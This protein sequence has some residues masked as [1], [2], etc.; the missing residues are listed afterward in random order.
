MGMTLFTYQIKR[1]K[2]PLLILSALFFSLTANG[3]NG[4][5]YELSNSPTQT[6]FMGHIIRPETAM[7]NHFLDNPALVHRMIE[8][9]RYFFTDNP[10]REVGVKRMFVATEGSLGEHE[11][12]FLAVQG[13]RFRDFS[14]RANGYTRS[15]NSTFLGKVGFTMGEH[16][17][18]G[19]NT[20][21]YPELYWPYIMADST[22]GDVKYEKYNILCAYS[23]KIKNV[24]FGVSGEYLG[25]FAFKQN[26]PRIEN[27]TSW[28][29]LKAGAAYQYRR[30]LFSLGLEYTLHRQYMDVRNFRSG[31]FTGFFVEYGFGM[32]DYI[33]SPVFNSTKQQEHINNV[34]ITLAFNS[35]PAKALRMN[36]RLKYNNDR[37]NTEEYTYKLNLYRALT[38]QFDFNYGLLW[39]N[40]TWGVNLLADIAADRRNGR[41]YLFERYVSSVVDG[42]DVYDYKKIG[43]QDRYRLDK[44]DGKLDAEISYFLNEHYTFALLGSVDYF[45]RNE[46]Y[47]E[48]NYQIKN[49]L[50]TP[51]AGL[52]LNYSGNK[53]DVRLR[54]CWGHRS[55]LDNQYRVG[56]EM[57]KH[58]EYQHAFAPYAYYGNNANIWTAELTVS[59]DFSFARLGLQAQMLCV[60]GKR[61]SDIRYDKERFEHYGL[62]NSRYAISLDP[63]VHNANWA[64]LTLFAEF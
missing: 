39:N 6:E 58:T 60:R 5:L 61:L 13:N 47:K 55:S 50:L 17:H 16:K 33:H 20:Q 29:T 45:M 21:R 18:V 12:D 41:E 28:L 48:K 4:Y 63:D 10:L 34:G 57:G 36:A 44:L 49:T 37:M 54:G 35:D 22:G 8:D 7:R 24:D 56:L 53:F 59:H 25:D 11:G 38:H 51:S 26:D 27:I 64:K 9:R 46:T 14:V 52:G 23:S 43:H 3:Q 2:Y 32:Y 62:N 31:Q 42:V 40:T 1:R 30:H 15:A 19:W